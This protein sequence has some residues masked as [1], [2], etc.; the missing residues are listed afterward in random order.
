[1][2]R[3]RFQALNVLFVCFKHLIAH[4]YN[5]ISYLLDP[6]LYFTLYICI[7]LW[8]FDFLL[9]RSLMSFKLRTTGLFSSWKKAKFVLEFWKQTTITRIKPANRGSMQYAIIKKLFL[10]C[11]PIRGL[12]GNKAVIPALGMAWSSMV[13]VRLMLSRTEQPLQVCVKVCCRSR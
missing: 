5:C 10:F 11:L 13:T 4:M 12:N 9:S 8:L 2:V 6:C 7:Y 3:I 1:M